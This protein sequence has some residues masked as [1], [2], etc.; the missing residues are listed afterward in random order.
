M[1]WDYHL[2]LVTLWHTKRLPWKMISLQ[3]KINE[4]NG[5]CCIRVYIY[6][7]TYIPYYLHYILCML[8]YIYTLDYLHNEFSQTFWWDLSGWNGDLSDK[9][10]T[11]LRIQSIKM[12]NVS[13]KNEEIANIQQHWLELTD[14][15]VPNQP[16]RHGRSSKRVSFSQ[17][18]GGHHADASI[19]NIPQKFGAPKWIS[20][21]A[22]MY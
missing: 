18:T 8:I 12:W 9:A 3:R 7:Y 14:Q 5:P 20:R 19:T 16:T 2:L 17:P 1:A 22:F 10:R 13:R 15:E 11:D 4:L 21:I 6:I